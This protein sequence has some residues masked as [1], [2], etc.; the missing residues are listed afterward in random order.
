[1]AVIS[2]KEGLHKAPLVSTLIKLGTPSFR[3]MEDP[4]PLFT[5]ADQCNFLNHLVPP[6][7]YTIQKD[8]DFL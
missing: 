1:M 8:Q 3:G 7:T 6:L 2:S 4:G 5:H